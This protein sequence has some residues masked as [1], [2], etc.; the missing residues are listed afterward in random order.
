MAGGVRAL[1]VDHL[2]EGGGDV[3]EIVVV[4]VPRAAPAR[5]ANTALLELGRA[6]RR[7]EAGVG[8]RRARTPS[9]SAG[10]NQLPRAARDLGSAASAPSAVWNTST[11]CASSAMRA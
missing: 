2:A 7:P 9:T 3:V 8:A 10:S 5:S 1:G 4:D 6:Q 11:T